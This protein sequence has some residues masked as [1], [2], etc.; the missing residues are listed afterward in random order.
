MSP[1]AEDD[2]NTQFVVSFCRK[3]HL[4]SNEQRFSQVEGLIV[5]KGVLENGGGVLVDDA[6]GPHCR[7]YLPGEWMLVVSRVDGAIQRFVAGGVDLIE[8]GRS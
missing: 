6:A 2:V 1:R 3:E 8:R 7:R 5:V 4:L